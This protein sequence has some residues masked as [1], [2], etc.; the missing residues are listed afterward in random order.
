M[1]NI[2]A[3]FLFFSF[4]GILLAIETPDYEVIDTL[5]DLVEVRKYAGATIAST[6][7][8]SGIRE[9]GNVGFR[10]L[11]GYIFGDN[12]LDKKIKMTAPVMQQ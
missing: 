5:P 8:A 6:T 4:S 7:V 2:L 1:Q 12:D 11:A 10:R 9:S 3:F